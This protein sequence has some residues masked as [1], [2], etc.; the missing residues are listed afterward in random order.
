MV[1]EVP[2]KSRFRLIFYS[3]YGALKSLLLFFFTDVKAILKAT[4]S[5]K[6][7]DWVFL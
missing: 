7:F 6:I 4:R 5:V 2:T 1:Q 3:L